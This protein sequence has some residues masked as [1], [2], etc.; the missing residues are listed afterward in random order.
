MKLETAPMHRMSRDIAVAHPAAEEFAEVA[1]V[2][3]IVTS[4]HHQAAL[5]TLPGHVAELLLQ[6][7][8]ECE[9]RDAP[10]RER[11]V[12]ADA[13]LIKSSQ[14]IGYM[15]AKVEER[16]NLARAAKNKYDS[17]TAS[18]RQQL[19]HQQDLMQA[20]RRDIRATE[21]TSGRVKVEL[22]KAEAEEKTV[23]SFLRK[24]GGNP[25]AVR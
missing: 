3:G 10:K 24:A 8:V 7:I 25:T 21:S 15:S 12:Q 4:A 19:G 5:R 22:V 16:D 18:Y 6:R 13:E 9:A 11:L 20:F 17:Q 14:T 23:E 2:T 1:F